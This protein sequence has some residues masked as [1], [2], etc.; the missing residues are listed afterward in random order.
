MLLNLNTIEKALLYTSEAAIFF[1]I[2]G[3]KHSSFLMHKQIIE[4]FNAYLKVQIKKRNKKGKKNPLSRA[5]PNICL[6]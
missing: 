4:I 3:N 6:K 2:A 1:D 5:S